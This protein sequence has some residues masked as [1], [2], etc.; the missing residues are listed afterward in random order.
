MKVDA[1]VPADLARVGSEAQRL[2]ALGYDG[3]RV[4]ELNH[5]PFMPLALAAEHTEKIELLT[6]VAVAEAGPHHSWMSS[7]TSQPRMRSQ[8]DRLAGRKLTSA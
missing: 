1:P 4:A 6:S 7:R 3:L 2:E 5:D 8:S